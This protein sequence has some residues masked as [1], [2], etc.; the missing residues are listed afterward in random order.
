MAADNVAEKGTKASTRVLSPGLAPPNVITLSSARVTPS[1]TSAGVT[2]QLF[3][4]TVPA[5][6]RPSP[7]S[8]PDV[9][10]AQSAQASAAAE[11]TL[12]APAP[13]SAAS[14]AAADAADE[15]CTIP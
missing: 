10:P 8:A 14:C 2:G 12:A 11:R 1:A 7:H 4:R 6:R 9:P 3:P 13:A 15:P 5:D